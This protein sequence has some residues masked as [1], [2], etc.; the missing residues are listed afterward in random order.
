LTVVGAVMGTPAYM[1]PEQARGDPVDA[2]ADVYALGAILYRALTG[3]KPF[4]GLDP[5]ATLTAVLVEEPPRPRSIA[6]SIPEALELVVQRAMAKQPSER[7]QSMEE[8]DALLV[9]FDSAA[10]V[11]VRGAPGAEGD[12]KTLMATDAATLGGVKA[13]AEAA[14]SAKRA[15]P[16]LL[17]ATLIGA[18]LG[19]AL[20]A[21]ALFA[22]IRWISG[23]A[24]PPSTG[25][26]VLSFAVAVALAVAP[27]VLWVR[28]IVRSVWSNTPRAIEL[29]DRAKRAL[30]AAAAAYALTTLAVRVFEILVRR[31]P[32]GV[33]HPMW[34]LLTVTV[35]LAVALAS[36]FVAKLWR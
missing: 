20:L 12:A 19:V 28:F 24:Q 1:A 18:A 9:P 36:W 34:T 8:L 22:L 4:E 35:T 31:A 27:V 16:K 6:G 2:R 3:R 14:R 17:L 23:A 7:I 30:F 10:N 29:A 11:T 13:V 5:M 32:E 25:V 33:T 21:D 26:I 15:R